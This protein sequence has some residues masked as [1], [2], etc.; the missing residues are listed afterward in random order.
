M[1]KDVCFN[2]NMPCSRRYGCFKTG[3]KLGPKIHRRGAPDKKLLLKRFGYIDP[4]GIHWDVPAGV[5]TDGATIPPGLKP[6]VGGSWT[7]AYIKAAVVHDFYIRKTTADP[8]KVHEMFLN[9]LLAS[10]VSPYWATMMY[11]GVSRFGP[12]WDVRDLAENERIRLDNIAAQKKF[13]REFH[14]RYQACV[15]S[16]KA[17]LAKAPSQRGAKCP[18]GDSE[19][20]VF[21]L[22]EIL[23]DQI[24][25]NIKRQLNAGEC[26]TLPDGMLDCGAQDGR[27]RFN[28]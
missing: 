21:G 13:D 4:Y 7:K 25:P 23:I 27:E 28:R 10:D 18:L 9:A 17:R 2:G 19:E 12:S 3:L 20:L 16:R 26:V 8:K 5:E 14:Q 1:A 6:I 15:Q 24:V 11:R 22:S